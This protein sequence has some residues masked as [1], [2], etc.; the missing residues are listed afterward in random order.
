[1][2]R[3][4]YVIFLLIFSILLNFTSCGCKHEWVEAT[5][6]SP[7]YCTLCSKTEG[8]PL[9]HDFKDATCIYPKTC[10]LCGKSQGDALGHDFLSA[11]YERPAT[12][13]RCNDIRGEKLTPVTN[14]G[15]NNIL[16]M[17]NALVEINSYKL[18]DDKNSYV[19]AT[20][21]MIKFE[22]GYRNICSRKA[23]LTYNPV[24]IRIQNND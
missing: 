3:R 4:N 5:C 24:Y 15:F 10:V 12:C 13:T 18:S 7:K 20:G 11:T 8:K 17:G 14:W 2:K 19:V 6:D 22:N 1:M 16:E 9:E 23:T 21:N